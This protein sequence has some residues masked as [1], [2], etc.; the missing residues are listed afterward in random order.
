M[1][2]SRFKGI[3]LYSGTCNYRSVVERRQ[4]LSKRESVRE[5]EKSSCDS[6]AHGFDTYKDEQERG[7]NEW[8]YCV[9]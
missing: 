9:T 8:E 2:Y 7:N 6:V 3:F 5:R 4:L 1:F